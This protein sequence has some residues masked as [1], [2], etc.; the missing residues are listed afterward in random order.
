MSTTFVND[1]TYTTTIVA[2]TCPIQGCGLVY[3]LSSEFIAARRRDIRVW[4]CPNGHTLS[5]R[6]Q[7]EAE[8]DKLRRQVEQSLQQQRDLYESLTASRQLAQ[9]AHRSAAAHKGHAT[10]LRNRIA[11][12]FC[13][14]GCDQQFPDIQAHLVSEHPEFTEHLVGDQ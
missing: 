4:Y 6:A 9:Q 1:I 12:G 10:R 8:A 7:A 2:V 11:Q 5:Y 3:G 14:A 13:P